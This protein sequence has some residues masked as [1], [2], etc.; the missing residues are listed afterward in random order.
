MR[1]LKQNQP[2]W[3]GRRLALF[4]GLAGRIGR[5]G[6]SQPIG[7]FDVEQMDHLKQPIILLLDTRHPF[8][9]ACARAAISLAWTSHGH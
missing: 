2:G 4:G 9:D 5:A 3:N 8:D 1:Y 6:H 7:S